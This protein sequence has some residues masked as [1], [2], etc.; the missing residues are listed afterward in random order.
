M[1]RF[2]GRIAKG[3]SLLLAI[4]TLSMAAP[5]ANSA[6]ATGAVP[7]APRGVIP[8]ASGTSVSLTWTAPSSDGGSPVTDYRIQYRDGT[9]FRSVWTTDPW[10][11]FTHTARQVPLPQSP[12]LLLT[13][14]MSF[15]LP[16]KT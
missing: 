2:A 6:Q 4:A 1:N 8:V 11:D 16:R 7:G 15:V 13:T 10:I 3:V 9:A 5:L 14:S 12:A